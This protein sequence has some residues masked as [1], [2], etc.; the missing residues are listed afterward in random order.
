MDTEEMRN[1][2]ERA[3]MPDKQTMQDHIDDLIYERNQLLEAVR[4][5][6][7]IAQ[8][9]HTIINNLMCTQTTNQST[10]KKDA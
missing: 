7:N 6:R 5:W 2:Y 9:R 10:E 8:V 3:T 4:Y 1:A